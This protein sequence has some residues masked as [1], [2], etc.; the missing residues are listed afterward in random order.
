M[1]GSPIENPTTAA[2]EIGTA[3]GPAGHLRAPLERGRAVLGRLAGS[4][5]FMAALAP[6][7]AAGVTL[8]LVIPTLA[9]GVANWDTAEFQTVAPVLGTAHPTGYPAYVIIGWLA[10]LLLT[11]FGEAAYRM[12]ILQALFAAGAIAATVAIVQLL[13]KMRWVALATGLLLAWTQLFWRLS[14]HADPHMLHAALV[15]VVFVLLLAWERR[16]V[17]DVETPLDTTKPL[18]WLLAGAFLYAV[19]VADHRLP[20]IVPEATGL[21]LMAMLF[22]LLLVREAALRR[23]TA[24]SGR[25][26]RWLVAAAFVYA[27]AVANHSLALLLPPAIGLFVLAVDPRILLRRRTIVAC[28]TVL[29][30]TIIAL[31]LELPIRAA[32][33]APLVY[34]HPDTW[35]GFAYVV[36]GQQFLG[37]L[38]DPLGNLPGKAAGVVNLMSGWL[39]PFGYLSMLG[40]ATSLVRRPRF[41]LLSGLAALVVLFFAASYA[42]GAID[43]YYMVPLLI[44]FV[45]MGLG[46]ADLVVGYGWLAD[47]VR[48][49]SGEFALRRAGALDSSPSEGPDD[50]WDRHARLAAELI[51]TLALVAPSIGI[52]SERQQASRGSHSE[53]VSESTRTGDERWMRAVLA[54][55]EAG[56]L[57]Q[58][59]VVVSWWSTSTTLWYGQKADGL[60]PDIYIVDDRTRLDDNLGTVQNTIDKFL[61]NRPVFTI[62]LDGGG[63]GMTAL[64]SRY[65][66]QPF[67]LPNGSTIAQVMARKGS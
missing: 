37:N 9:P 16:R 47:Q 53:G 58:D 25:A 28:V 33:H 38:S 55:P 17:G 64:R 6:L 19:A 36:L 15:G 67:K 35:S 57:P 42:D 7:I 45:W 21:L 3:P 46:A 65:V 18:R 63:D 12:N 49:R 24:P 11:P 10:S 59:A 40:V 51:F 23:N 2:P 48:R 52:V 34:G 41:V 62:R 66:V 14:T 50:G 4:G 8:W 13:T 20:L 56:G 22:I 39:G 61:G 26:D 60:R 44:A 1:A 30:V 5:L 32:M 43:R 29:A 31:F 27:V 54:M